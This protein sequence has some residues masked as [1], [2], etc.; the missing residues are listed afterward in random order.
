MRNQMPESPATSDELSADASFVGI[1]TW[2]E[3]HR[4]SVLE[5]DDECLWRFIAF[6][7]RKGEPFFACEICDDV[8]EHAVPPRS[9]GFFRRLIEEKSLFLAQTGS[10]DA[11]EALLNEA[12]V[13]YGA[14][15]ELLC[16]LG[17][18]SKDRWRRSQNG[19]HDHLEQ[20][21][22]FYTRAF[23]EFGSY[24]PAINAAALAVYL[25]K[26][27]EAASLATEALRL[28]SSTQ[29]SP[30]YWE[31]ATCAEA[32][33][34][35]GDLPR[36]LAT[37]QEAARLAG[38]DYAKTG[39]TRNQAAEI[40]EAL[41]FDASPI[42]AIFET[43]QV[44]I[45]TGHR[46]DTPGRREPRFPSENEAAVREAIAVWLEERRI[47]IGYC[48]AASGGDILFAECLL[49][50]G[51]ECHIV[52]PF[53]EQSFRE[54]SVLTGNDP[55]WGERFDRV[56]AR[57]SSVMT[58]A[59]QVHDD[60]V[61]GFE[62]FNFADRLIL[63]LG[64][65]KS[66]MNGGPLHALAVWDGC[67]LDSPTGRA[68]CVAGW[69][70]RGCDVTII[71]SL[72]PFGVCSVSGPV[73][74]KV[75]PGGENVPEPQQQICS[76]VFSDVVGYSKMQETDIPKYLSE[77]RSRI[78]DTIQSSGFPLLEINTWGDAFYIVTKR[79]SEAGLLALRMREAT[80]HTTWHPV[81]QEPLK[82]RT[83]VHAGPLFKI[84]DAVTGRTNYT[85]THTSFGARIEPITPEGQIFAS[86]SFAALCAADNVSDFRVEYVG[87]KKLDKN[88]GSCRLFQIIG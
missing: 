84:L 45:F 44:A 77:F 38:A 61:L 60:A 71:D 23:R 73:D 12:I 15:E 2:W 24:Y 87:R 27:D 70:A 78:L 88:Y 26:L 80:R 52:L 1:L 20:G 33:L 62:V 14:S 49:E 51:A 67:N 48:S 40:A 42:T 11:S 36:A 69:R 41:G 28:A 65:L 29:N 17:R 35:L 25:G 31:V 10:V 86:E 3:R 83:S 30:D 68:F 6:L 7:K 81:G 13:Q 34:I 76:I 85:G 57:A 19:G 16:R 22:S 74:S 21:L 4:Q 82:L 64:C 5:S 54:K 55:S 53:R 9:A 72:R 32:H 47:R 79:V 18:L 66:K 58:A 39:T 43:P 46:I 59:N 63:G 75:P 50:R 8:L 56:I 37:Y